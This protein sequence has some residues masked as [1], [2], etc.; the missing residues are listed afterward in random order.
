MIDRGVERSWPAGRIDPD[1]PEA[2]SR[3][4]SRAGCEFL[5]AISAEGIR[6]FGSLP[7]AIFFKAIVTA[8]V[9]HITRSA[10]RTWRYARLDQIA[11][12]S[13]R[14]PVSILGLA[15]SLH[16]PFETT[17]ENVNALIGEGLVVK[18]EGGV[19]VPT[20]VLLSDL[21]VAMDDR[22]WRSFCEMIASLKSL[23]FDF[24]VVLGEAVESSAVV[25]QDHFMPSLSTRSPRRLVSR[26]ISEFYLGSAVEANAQHGDDW[27]M[28][29]VSTGFIMANSAAWRLDP[30]Q[31]WLFS[32]AKSPM[33]DSL[34]APA[35]IAQVARLTGLGEKLV[36]RKAHDLVDAGRLTRLR[37]GFLVSIDYMNG[38]EIRAGAAA[39]VSAFYRMIRD[40]KALGVRL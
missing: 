18:K 37:G 36:R 14:R 26:V 30:E 1:S 10:V 25:I 39:I 8:N 12:E 7:R 32:K 23:N 17:R 27:V 4:I 5:L 29:Q 20:E 38:P 3:V 24:S 15:Q 28:G 35:S 2:P 9:Q 16:R 19:I 40:L 11:P 34:Q 21:V 31:A 33:P 22:L 13:E 6:T